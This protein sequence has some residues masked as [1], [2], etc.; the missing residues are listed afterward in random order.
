MDNPTTLIPYRENRSVKATVAPAVIAVDDDS[1]PTSHP[2]GAYLARLGIGSRDTMKR[3]LACALCAIN[4]GLQLDEVDSETSRFYHRQVW[5]TEWNKT[6]RAWMLLLFPAL[7]NVGYAPYTRQRIVTA[8]RGVLK[9]CRFMELMSGDDYFQATE[10]LPKI[11]ADA[12]PAGR[13]VDLDEYLWLLEVCD[14]DPKRRKGVR[15]GAILSLG[16]FIGPR[17]SE[18]ARL[19]MPDYSPQQQLITLRVSKNNKTRHVPF[20]GDAAR[21][22]DEWIAIRGNDPGR[23]FCQVDTAGNVRIRNMRTG[24]RRLKFITSKDTINDILQRRIDEAGLVERF[25]FHD[26]RR[27]CTTEI[28]RKDGLE[29]AQR[30]LG[31]SSISTTGRYRIIDDQEVREAMAKRDIGLG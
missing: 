10:H 8:V 18:V 5:V 1:L 30:I 4:E 20:F 9:E 29:I 15:D 19:R 24:V 12:P 25:I 21:R 2:V 26:F 11:S 23:I 3:G 17:S 7:E 28:S 16:H 22:M 14:K 27:T 31:H 6:R 13:A